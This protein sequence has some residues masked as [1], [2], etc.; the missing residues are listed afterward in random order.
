[1]AA[2]F[3]VVVAAC[4]ICPSLL[5][6]A[7]SPS[8]SVATWN[9]RGGHGVTLP[10]GPAP[11]DMNSANCDDPLRPRNAWGLGLPQRVLD[12]AIAADPSVIAL[13]VQE[14]W[15]A[16]GNVRNVAARL[17]WT[18]RSPERGG[19]GL[20]ARHGIVGTWEAWQIEFR[21]V[22]GAPEDRWIVGAN[23]CVTV[24]C[25]ATVYVWVTHL[26]ATIDEEWPG[27]AGKVI[28]WLSRRNEPHV[29]AGDFNIW[30]NDRWSPA[31]NCGRATPPMAVAL[32]RLAAAGYTDAWTVA[33]S[34]E[35]W[36]STVGRTGCGADAAGSAYKRVD[37][38]WSKGLEVAAAARF[39]MVPGGDPAPSD[40]LGVKATFYFGRPLNPSEIIEIL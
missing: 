26:S 6:R 16:C 18:A 37:Y 14:A 33:R 2:A 34:G 22:A 11:F 3:R 36:T 35:G 9:L 19:V 4:L 29:L 1:M 17:G 20:I 7:Q 8:F 32:A 24:D 31:T 12:D 23:V 28:D 15:G 25:T 38:V 13:G 21:G 39:G 27:H 30:Q 40:H 10:G 5:L